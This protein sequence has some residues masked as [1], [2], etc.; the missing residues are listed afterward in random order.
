MTSNS[1]TTHAARV[2]FRGC[3][4]VKF[5]VILSA[6]VKYRN[7]KFRTLGSVSHSP[8]TVLMNVNINT[9]RSACRFGDTVRQR[10]EARGEALFGPA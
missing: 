4:G 9:S 7:S 5:G 10:A 6:L 1:P 8:M 3:P 2:I